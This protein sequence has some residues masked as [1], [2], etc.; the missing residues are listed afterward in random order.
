[1][2]LEWLPVVLALLPVHLVALGPSLAAVLPLPAAA[3]GGGGAR[4]A[5]GIP[6]GRKPP[7]LVVVPV[8]QRLVRVV[9]LRE[10]VDGVLGTLWLRD[11]D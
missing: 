3:A 9:L 5:A 2:T 6:R 10:A 1:M 8:Q 7:P 11:G 4:V